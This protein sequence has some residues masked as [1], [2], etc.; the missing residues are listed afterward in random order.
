[1]EKNRQ[2]TAA[3]FSPT[4]GT[5]RAVEIFTEFLTQNPRYLDL[6]RRK[7]RKEKWKFSSG[8]FLVAAAPVYGG[9][10]PDI[11]E[12]LFSNLHG[13]KTPCV[14]MAAYGNRHYDDTLA[15]MQYR[16]EEQGFICIGAIAPVIPHIYSDILGK[17]RPDEKD[18]R[19]IRK[20]AVEIKKRLETGEQYGFTS[21]KVPGNPLPAPKQMKPVE[22]SFDR[23][24]CTKCQVCVQRCPVNAISQETLQIR[25]DRCLNCMSCVKVC[26]AG[27]RGYDCSQVADYLEKNYSVPKEIQFF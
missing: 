25:E 20:F 15:Q 14:I 16:L 1:M 13:E 22:K 5:R 9:Q 23:A 27:A 3:F 17:G 24:R 4:G 21:V 7:L 19:I 26:K 11:Q 8:D 2:V 18:I 6:G 10:L 12:P